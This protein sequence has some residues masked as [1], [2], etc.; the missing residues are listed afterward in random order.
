MQMPGRKFNAGDG[1][2]YGFNGKE[3]DNEVKGEGN[4]QDYGF[5]IYDPRLSRFL[6]VD[7]L[8]KSYP[9]YTPYSFAGNKPIKYIDFDGL[10][11]A[12][13]WYDYSFTDLMNFVSKPGNPAPN[14]GFVHKAG[15]AFNRN[16]NPIFFTYVIAT[17]NDP[18]SSDNEKM[19]RT[20]AAVNLTTSLVLHKSFSIAARPTAAAAVEQQ[21]AKNQTAMGSKSAA[22]VVAEDETAS[23]ASG[24]TTK[25]LQVGEYGAMAKANAKTGQS[26]D[27]IPSF[28]AVKKYTE[29][30]LGRK[31]TAAEASGLRKST[32]TIV[33]ET[34]LHQTASRTFAGRNNPLQIAKDA[35]NL[36]AA[37]KQDIQALTPTLLKSGYS[38]AEIEVAQQTLMQKYSP[39]K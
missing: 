1:Y 12:K 23:S 7:P 31:L 38:Q 16:F 39:K 6:S 24:S 2:R 30:A 29:T 5:R 36:V 15:S 8:T 33:Y 3:N 26:A 28:A 21:M 14:D 27:H 18:S 9:H 17:G 11:E 19:N 32:L 34:Q 10:E 22:K 4:Q 13:H 20:E 25:K 37:V 35:A